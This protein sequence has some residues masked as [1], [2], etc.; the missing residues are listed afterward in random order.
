MAYE[1]LRRPDVQEAIAAGRERLSRKTGITQERVLAG[2]LQTLG[3]LRD[4]AIAAGKYGP[5]IQ[6][7]IARG[8]ASGLY[9]EKVERPGGVEVAIVKFGGQC[10]LGAVQPINHRAAMA[11]TCT[12]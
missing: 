2:H 10:P 8:K 1:L 5:A 6:A 12:A 7:E 9:V 4:R 11:R 3:E